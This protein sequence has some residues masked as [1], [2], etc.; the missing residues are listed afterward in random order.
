VI[1]RIL[2][3]SKIAMTPSGIKPATFRFVTQ[4]LNHCATAVPPHIY[5]YIYI[6]ISI[7][8]NTTFTTVY[9]RKILRAIQNVFCLTFLNNIAN[10]K[11]ASTR[12]PYNNPYLFICPSLSPQQALITLILSNCVSCF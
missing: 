5:I 10:C 3:Q 1:G 2:C 4:H 7:K 12:L 11:F 9:K 6:Y 8:H